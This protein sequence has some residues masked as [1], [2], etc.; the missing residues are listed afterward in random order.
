[1]K[2]LSTLLYRR[3]ALLRQ[4]RLAN[5]A[6]AYA[7][8]QKFATRIYHAGLTGRVT[9]KHAAPQAERYWAS[10][11]AHDL[12]QS[13]I[14]EHFTD[15]DLMEMADVVS[16]MTANEGLDIT[17]AID[18]LGELF[19]QPVRLELERE[20]VTIDRTVAEVEE[21]RRLE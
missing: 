13:L 17:F 3:P 2:K 5:L 4:A 20:G 7:T 12:N 11:T 15:E 16:F 18:E 19:L 14:E 10:L 1:M 9:L 8:L 21:P 6:F